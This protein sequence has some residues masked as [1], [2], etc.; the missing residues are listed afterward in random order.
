MNTIVER[1]L[2]TEKTL[3]LAARGWY[4]FVVSEYATKRTI[5]DAVSVFYK[6]TVIDVR[7]ISMHGKVR[8][9]GKMSKHVKKADWKKAMVRLAKGQK[10]DA[11]EV[12]PPPETEKS[13][14]PEKAAK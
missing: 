8:R 10:I 13:A 3:T 5:K 14:K 12:A 2:I 6:V 9:V 4:T 11:F 1:P 7:T